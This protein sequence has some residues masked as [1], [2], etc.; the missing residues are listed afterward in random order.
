[1][2]K[3]CQE[4]KTIFI[5]YRNSFLSKRNFVLF[6]LLFFVTHIFLNP[7]KQYALRVQY[8]VS[9]WCFVFLLFDLYYLLV[10]ILACIYF[11]SNVPFLNYHQIYR[12]VRLGKVK[13][14]IYQII[15]IFISSI[16][17]VSMTLWMTVMNLFPHVFWE[18]DW[19]KIIYTLSLTNSGEQYHVLLDFSYDII[20]KYNPLQ[21]VS[22]VFLIGILV[23][24]FLGNIMFVLSLYFSRVVALSIASV[25]AAMII[26]SENMYLFPKMIFITPL[27]WLRL[28]HIQ[29]LLQKNMPAPEIFLIVVYLFVG[30]CIC[31][32][33]TIWKLK[34][35]EYSKYIKKQ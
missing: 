25:E 20:K 6:F 1:M 26:M 14:G 32:M 30:N 27:S 4:I 15:N 12:I 31:I 35:V 10:F 2:E 7:I 16:L 28:S 29:Y 9:V 13:W 8:R 24:F 19:G 21:V 22:L 18:N 23:V 3:I 17:L 5:D 33:L 11:F 34:D